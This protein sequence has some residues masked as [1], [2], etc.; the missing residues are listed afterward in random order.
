MIQQDRREFLK[1]LGLGAA[2]LAAPSCA[3]T[4]ARGGKPPN[5]VILF[6]D[7]QRFDTLHAVNCPAIKTPAMDRLVKRGVTFTRAHIMGGT[8]GAVCMPSRAMLLTGR[9]LFHLEQRGATIPEE[10]AM[11]PEVLQAA[12]YRTFGTGK[13]HNGRPAYA[14]CFTAGGKI[15]FGGMSDHDKVPVYDFDPSGKYEKKDQYIGDKFSSELFTDEAIGFLERDAGDEPFF[16][17][18]SYTAP[19]DPRMA[20]EP[21]ASMYPPEEI[22][23]PENFLPAHPF[24]NGEMRV[25]DE[26]LA[27][28]LRTPE[29]IREHLSA[30]HAMITHLDAQIGRLLDALERRGQADNTI[31][32]FAADNG[33]A[34]GSH[35]LLGKQNLYDHSVRVPLVI[36]GPGI[37]Q[38]VRTSGLWYLLDLFPTLCALTGLDVPD[39]V[40]GTSIA[41]AL[42]DPSTPGRDSVF[43][44]YTKLQRGVRTDDDWKLIKY[45]VKGEQHTQ[46]FDLNRDPH[47]MNDL[48]GDA[49]YKDRLESL[50]ALLEEHMRDLDDF[51]DLD[52]P[53]WG[54]PEGKH[55]KKKVSH[56]AKGKKIMLTHPYSPKYDGGGKDALLDGVRAT[57][58][59]SD[60]SWQGFEGDD[61]DA[62]I[63]LG[64]VR[65]IKKIRAGFLQNHGSWIF[66][67]LLVKFYVS[68]N[69]A[70]FLIRD[71]QVEDRPAPGG[72]AQIRDVVLDFEDTRAR[73][74]RVVAKNRG[75][76][77]GWHPGAGGKAWLFVDEIMVK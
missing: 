58:D 13:W 21:Y 38:D 11:L 23:L 52:K 72:A 75:T 63:D 76:C 9:T 16:L 40:E 45:N 51:C 19:H 42:R 33:L 47:E 41:P 53:N 22:E 25:R 49:R 35:G 71:A 43:L 56:M 7:D 29:V 64:E 12:G 34:V 39:T 69:G 2:A 67:P 32:V 37:P 50:T 59:F 65:D 3:T 36:C 70:E 46:L 48:A 6:T 73:Y 54:L 8:S 15:M 18:V 14:R 62:M 66:L 74:V 57:T 26:N 20:P 4:P 5:I 68:E 1:T 77:P 30:Y 44:A 31:I 17:Y 55:K 10:H 24:D 28:R 60:G 61:L 27:P